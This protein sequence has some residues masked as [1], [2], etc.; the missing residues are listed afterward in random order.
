MNGAMGGWR[1]EMIEMY[2]ADYKKSQEEM[3]CAESAQTHPMKRIN[4]SKTSFPSANT[5]ICFNV[6][7][8]AVDWRN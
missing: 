2:G 5:S 1:F 6:T 7:F 3:F 8:M 4:Y